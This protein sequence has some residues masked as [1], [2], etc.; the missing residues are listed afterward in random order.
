MSVHLT[1]SGSAVDAHCA[2]VTQL[3][4]SAKCGCALVT[5]QKS[6][7]G[8]EVVNACTITMAMDHYGN[9]DN[10]HPLAQVWK[11]LSQ[12]L[13]LT[14]AFLKIDGRFAGCIQNY[15]RPSACSF[16]KAAVAV[17]LDHKK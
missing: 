10:K 12:P 15:L 3:L 14:C 13:G 17:N 9:H 7:E 1:V 16:Q 6:I 4:R 2:R 8:S 11:A 5:P